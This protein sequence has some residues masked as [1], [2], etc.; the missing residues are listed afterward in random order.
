MYLFPTYTYMYQFFREINS[1]NE[2]KDTQVSR[3]FDPSYFT[4]DAVLTNAIMTTCCFVQQ[5]LCPDAILTWL[6]F[7][8]QYYGRRHFVWRY[9]F[10]TPFYSEY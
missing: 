4:T 1:E 3:Y 6:H 10:R 5:L 9:Y 8:P 2:S 7:V